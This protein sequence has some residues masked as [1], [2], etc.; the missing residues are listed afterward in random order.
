MSINAR[1]ATLERAATPFESAK[2]EQARRLIDVLLRDPA[3]SAAE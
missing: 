1:L 3:A 2:A